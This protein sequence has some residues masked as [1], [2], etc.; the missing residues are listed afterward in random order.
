V[1]DANGRSHDVAGLYVGDASVIPASMSVN[2]SL[3]VM[4]FAAR[5]ADHLEKELTR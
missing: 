4:A 2:P 1:V 3:T 5:L